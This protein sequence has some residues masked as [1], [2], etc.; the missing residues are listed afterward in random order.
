[1]SRLRLIDDKAAQI[2]WEY[3]HGEFDEETN[4]AIYNIAHLNTNHIIA[5]TMILEIAYRIGYAKSYLAPYMS[6]VTYKEK[7]KGLRNKLVS[8]VNLGRSDKER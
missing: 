2:C 5:I 3:I 4:V 1:M 6:E 8:V 7:K